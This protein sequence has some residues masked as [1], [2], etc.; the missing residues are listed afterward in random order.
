MFEVNEINVSN[1]KTRKVEH[2]AIGL[3]I[4]NQK[5]FAQI[6]PNNIYHGIAKTP[7]LENYQ[8]SKEKNGLHELLHTN[9]VATSIIIYRNLIQ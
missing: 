1:D 9:Y 8:K 3:T 5:F 2:N 4:N 6:M 7:T